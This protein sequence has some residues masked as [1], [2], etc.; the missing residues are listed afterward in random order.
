MC[1]RIMIIIRIITVRGGEEEQTL[2]SEIHTIKKAI[3]TYFEQYSLI[4]ISITGRF[5]VCQQV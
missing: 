3:A 1:S 2:L 4:S 5:T